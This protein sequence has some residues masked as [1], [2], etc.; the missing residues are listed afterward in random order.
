MIINLF[1]P[2]IIVFSAIFSGS[3]IGKI[4]VR[5]F[6]LGV[7]GVLFVSIV[8]GC[9]LSFCGNVLDVG[10]ADSLWATSKTVSS[11]GTCIFVA[12]IGLTSGFSDFRAN[13]KYI[14]KY[15]GIGVIVPLTG[16]ILTVVI[17]TVD[18]TADESTLIGVLCG[19][20]T[21][22]PAL[23]ASQELPGVNGSLSTLG[24]GSAYLYGVF[25]IVTFV[26]IIAKRAKRAASPPEQEL[27]RSIDTL[28]LIALS[29]AIGTIL[30]K[31]PLFNSISLGLSGG[32]LLAGMCVGIA[33][34]KINRKKSFDYKTINTYRNLGL[35]MF[36]VGEGLPAGYALRDQ[37][38]VKPLIYGIAISTAAI[39]FGFFCAR[40][41]F[42]LDKSTCAGVLA[43][44]MTST[45][46]V[47][48][49]IDS[50]ID[51]NLPSFSAA[52]VCSMI[53]M[54]VGVRTLGIMC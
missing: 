34:K 35:V 42:K 26:Q 51:V 8:T 37:F 16:I 46:A 38:G 48:T 49:L 31:V 5:G 13:L 52:Y 1:S 36:F 39:L 40:I 24:Y 9:V 10:Y 7:S 53:T 17:K 21:N 43:G 44:G 41:I 33:Y 4:K 19:A 30:G 20:M 50:G 3:L 47:N 14:L 6:S 32:V 28:P 23:A 54:I 22:T 29:V 27:K 18:K 25:S 15:C 2:L 12:S 45:P 11:F